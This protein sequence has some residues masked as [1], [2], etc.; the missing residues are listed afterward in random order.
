MKKRILLINPWIYDFAAYDFWIKPT[1]LLYW[2]AILRKNGHEVDVLDCL[3]PFHPGLHQEPRINIPHRHLV[4]RGKYPKERICK[5]DLLQAFPRRFFRYGITPRLFKESLEKNHK[6]DLIM[7]TSM[8]T[9]WYPGVY[10]AINLLREIYRDVTIVLGGNYVALCPEHAAGSGADVTIGI[11]TNDKICRILGEL[12]GDIFQFQPDDEDPDSWPYPAY[13]LLPYFDQIP[14][15]TS[16]GCPFHCSYCASQILQPRFI[17][18]DPLRVLDEIVF[19]RQRF[20]IRHF[21]FYDD[22]LLV[23]PDELIIPL[24]KNLIDSQLS[25]LFHCPNGLHVRHISEDLSRLMFQSGFKTIRL[26]FETS[27]PIRQAQT[28]DKVTG[29]ELHNAIMYLKKAGYQGRDI[30]VYLLCGLPGQKASEVQDSIRFVQECGAR[31]LIAEFSPVPQTLLW[32]DA[33]KVSPYPIDKEPLFQ[34]NT[35]L[36]CQSAD[37]D[38]GMYQKLKKS[39][40]E[41]LPVD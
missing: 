31:A 20:G 12:L 18:R 7:V 14:L 24:L 16:R 1:G 23:N 17:Q 40:K 35:L 27:D 11:E 5:P 34:N 36:P 10:D 33:V 25:C 30:G 13:D 32:E 3:N 8:M 15:L 29:Q 37:L 38:Y 26:G 6:P 4:G 9:Y 41:N 2:A 28:G 22:A 39:S 21:S 19:W